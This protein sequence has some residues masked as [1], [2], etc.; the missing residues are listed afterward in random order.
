MPEGQAIPY[1]KHPPGIKAKKEGEGTCWEHNGNNK[2]IP[3]FRLN[4][5]NI[6][7]SY[8]HRVHNIMGQTFWP[9]GKNLGTSRHVCEIIN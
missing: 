4:G 5:Q 8:S 7:I 6:F 2:K 3:T 1:A 9:S